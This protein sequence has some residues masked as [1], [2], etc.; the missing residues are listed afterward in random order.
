M[1]SF[2][3]GVVN[4]IAPTGRNEPAGRYGSFRPERNR[5]CLGRRRTLRDRLLTLVP[6]FRGYR[7]EQNQNRGSSEAE[8]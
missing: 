4:D 2:V 3:A 6:T 7:C 1:Q 8:A 5:L